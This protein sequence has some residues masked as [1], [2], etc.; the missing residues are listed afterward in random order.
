MTYKLS[1][2]E[3]QE[4]I[5]L[6][7]SDRPEAEVNKVIESFPADKRRAVEEFLA[8]LFTPAT[9]TETGQQIPKSRA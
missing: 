3:E 4:I 8:K 5:D 1:E 7:L 9:P 6:C 2:S